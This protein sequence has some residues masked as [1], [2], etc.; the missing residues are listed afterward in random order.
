MKRAEG[1]V[2]EGGDRDMSY[3]YN[4]AGQETV[5]TGSHLHS[6]TTVLC[7]FLLSVVVVVATGSPRAPVGRFRHLLLSFGLQLPPR[8]LHVHTYMYL[9]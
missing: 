8:Y 3:C 2:R 1:I 9:P 5:V 7:C 6:P 4:G